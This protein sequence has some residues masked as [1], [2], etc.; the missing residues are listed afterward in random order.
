MY[1]PGTG[2]SCDSSVSVWSWHWVNPTQN[3]FHKPY[4]RH[5]C[6]LHIHGC[7]QD[8]RG[9]Y[10]Q[11][12]KPPLEFNSYIILAVF[13]FWRPADQFK[14]YPQLQEGLR[15]AGLESSNLILGTLYLHFANQSPSFLIEKESISQKVTSGLANGHSVGWIFIP[16]LLSTSTPT[17][18]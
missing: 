5:H 7:C 14:T 2:W 18:Q 16:Y 4:P 12:Q 3:G 9:P 8:S 10:K 11:E 13:L 6:G 17:N 1:C 15:A